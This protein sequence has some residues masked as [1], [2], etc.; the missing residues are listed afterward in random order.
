MTFLKQII[1]EK[2][3]I[4]RGKKSFSSLAANTEKMHCGPGLEDFLG[5]GGLGPLVPTIRISLR[6]DLKVKGSGLEM[7]PLD[8]KSVM[9]VEKILNCSFD[10]SVEEH[11]PHSVH[12]HRRE[13]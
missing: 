13:P 3:V 2:T 6:G 11:V 8:G 7:K 9:K 12:Q 1:F 5:L 10:G 4:L